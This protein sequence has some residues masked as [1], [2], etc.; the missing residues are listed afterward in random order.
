MTTPSVQW[1]ELLPAEFDQRLA[2]RP[3]VYLPM[4]LC[5]PHGLA[6]AFGLDTLKAEH[7]CIAAAQRFGGIVAPTQ[8]YH[9]HE[10]GYHAPFLETAVG[11]DNPRL[12]GLPPDIILRTLLFQF[13]AFV[14]AG[15]RTI[16]VVSGHNGAQADL[17]FVA[18][19]FM[20]IA[21]VDIVVNSDPEL[22]RGVISGDHAGRFEL[23]QLMHARPELVN[24]THVVETTDEYGPMAQGHDAHEATAEYG[25]YILE[26]M[27]DRV[28]QLLESAEA[29][30]PPG[31]TPHRFLTFDDVEPAWECVDAAREQWVSL[32]P[33]GG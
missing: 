12:G 30:S 6:A 5:E 33:V 8:G 13:R 11:A 2:E 19:E 25:Q 27:I 22:V 4:G 23:S 29:S 14:N 10:S 17:R 32:G 18:D 1:Q 16:M 15:F 7:I 9:V 24:L 21:D 3:V 26:L 20:K 31:R 28:G